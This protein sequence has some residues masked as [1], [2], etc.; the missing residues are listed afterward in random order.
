MKNPRI[1]VVTVTYFPRIMKGRTP[2][3]IISRR[4]SILLPIGCKIILLF[5]EMQIF[6]LPNYIVFIY[7]YLFLCFLFLHISFSSCSKSP[8]LFL[9]SPKSK[10]VMPFGSVNIS[11]RFSYRY[12]TSSIFPFVNVFLFIVIK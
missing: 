4:D 5:F 11:L 8:F 12:S 1:S 2:F 3:T 9:N 6:C 7:N 10:D